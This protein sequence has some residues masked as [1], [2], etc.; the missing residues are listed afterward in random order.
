MPL[1]KKWY[2]DPEYLGMWAENNPAHPEGYVD[3]FAK[4]IIENFAKHPSAYVKN[5]AQM[6]ALVNPALEKIFMGEATAADA[7]NEIAPQI[8]ALADGKFTE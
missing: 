1:M 6:D 2:T 7:M 5:F 4:P 3:A 8:E